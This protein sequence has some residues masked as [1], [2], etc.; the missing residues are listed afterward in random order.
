MGVLLKNGG[1]PTY[2]K[3][4]S[5]RKIF[6]AGQKRTGSPRLRKGKATKEKAG[7]TGL[8]STVFSGS[9]CMTL[10]CA[11]TLTVKA[12]VLPLQQQLTM[13][14]VLATI[15]GMWGGGGVIIFWLHSWPAWLPWSRWTRGTRGPQPSDL[16]HR[17]T[18]CKI[19]IRIW[20][21]NCTKNNCCK[22][23]CGAG[24]GHFCWSRSRLKT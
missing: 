22:Q 8:E 15:H 18:I 21:N 1:K 2:Y 23:C 13:M 12:S 9:G 6:G 17:Y 5:R 24:A 19:H 11:P 16:Q 10:P 14:L 20:Q 7:S 4:W 3:S